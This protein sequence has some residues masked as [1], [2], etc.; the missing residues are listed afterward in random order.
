MRLSGRRARNRRG[1]H[2]L[3]FAL[4]L[5]ILS[6]T[7]IGF[8][9]LGAGVSR[10]QQLAAAAR[11]GARWA[12]VHGKQYA[13]DTG[14][15]AATAQDVYSQVIAPRLVGFNANLVTYSV[16]WNTDNEPYHVTT[17]GSGNQTKV[18]NIVTVKVSYQWIPEA[19]LGGKTLTSTSAM[20]MYY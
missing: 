12:S 9:V 15:N 13:R 1:A 11:E 17:D 10:Y 8:L 6:L 19:F 2:L 3:E 7:L 4:L 16:T 18:R 5:P 14:Q 20:L